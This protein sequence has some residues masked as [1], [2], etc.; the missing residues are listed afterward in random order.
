[1]NLVI[2][3]EVPEDAPTYLHRIGRAGRFGSHGVSI[4]FISSQKDKENFHEG[5]RFHRK[6]PENIRNSSRRAEGPIPNF[7]HDWAMENELEVFNSGDESDQKNKNKEGNESRHF[8]EISS[9]K[10]SN[11]DKEN[12]NRSSKTF[13]KNRRRA[14]C[15][16]EASSSE[17]EANGNH[18]TR[19]HHFKKPPIL[20]ILTHQTNGPKSFV[21]DDEDLFEDY[22]KVQSKPTSEAQ[23]TKTEDRTSQ[24]QTSQSQ[25]G[26]SD[27]EIDKNI[28][29]KLVNNTK[30]DFHNTGVRLFEL[31]N[32]HDPI[33]LPDG[34]KT[35][36]FSTVCYKKEIYFLFSGKDEIGYKLEELLADRGGPP[37]KSL[38]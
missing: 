15:D 38:N 5:H 19:K 7:L 32:P 10:E 3:L 12:N 27:R 9:L 28:F 36:L 29:N 17:S 30:K 31:S 21:S 2:N 26:D 33:A 24:S 20:D 35:F 23:T 18:P 11:S 16:Q 8:D 14:D 1:M 22:K 6:R 4:T 37:M 34:P 13:K 25:K